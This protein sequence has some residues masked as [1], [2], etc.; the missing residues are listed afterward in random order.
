MAGE[1]HSSGAHD[2]SG[3]R[4]HVCFFFK[5]FHSRIDSFSSS[6]IFREAVDPELLGIPTYFDIIPRKDARDLR[7]IR[8]KLD[9]DKYDSIGA[10]EV[11]IDLMVR[12]AVTFNGADSEVGTM[13]AAFRNRVSELLDVKSVST[14]KRKD[15]EKGTPQPTKKVK[16]GV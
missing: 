11:D 1:A 8:Q 14:K 7:L 4:R 6:W 9:S 5:C 12:N 16:L 15:S 3:E 10:F 13:A 2:Y